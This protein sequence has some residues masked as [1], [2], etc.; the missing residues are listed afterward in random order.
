MAGRSSSS[1]RTDLRISNA[2]RLTRDAFEE[3]DPRWS[4]DGSRIAFVSNRAGPYEVFV[5]DPRGGEPQRVTRAQGGRAVTPAWSPDGKRIAF[6]A[7]DV[8]LFLVDAE[9][10]ESPGERVT[11]AA[12]S[13]I[14]IMPG[15]WSRDGKLLIG[16]DGRLGVYSFADRSLR[17]IDL[18]ATTTSWMPD[19]RIL[20]GSGATFWIVDP[21]G[22]RPIELSSVG[23]SLIAPHVS[24]APD[25]RSLVFSVSNNESDI[26]V[27]DL[28]R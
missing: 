11:D 24:L 14:R 28:R 23:D 6:L 13:P 17:T 27:A 22:T 1:P 18:P 9:S 2:R 4:P 8:G 3:H 15:D 25:R 20:V 10:V 12:G 21:E 16:T 26:W 19:G 7:Q 5:L